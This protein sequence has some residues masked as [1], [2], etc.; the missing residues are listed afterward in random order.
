[1]YQNDGQVLTESLSFA[2]NAPLKIFEFSDSQPGLNTNIEII[3]F[4]GFFAIGLTTSI[5]AINTKRI[6]NNVFKI[7]QK[8]KEETSEKK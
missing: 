1:M 7:L 6:K 2:V 8:R 5:I 3:A 4:T